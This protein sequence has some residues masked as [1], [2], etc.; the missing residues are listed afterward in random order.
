M[1]EVFQVSRAERNKKLDDVIKTSIKVGKTYRD[2][3][4]F[5][6]QYWKSTQEWKDNFDRVK[7]IVAREEKSSF[8]VI[9]KKYTFTE[10]KKKEVLE[11]YKFESKFISDLFGDI[12]SGCGC[13]DSREY[14]FQCSDNECRLTWQKEC[15]EKDYTLKEL[16]PDGC[17]CCA[18]EEYYPHM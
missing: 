5:R 8:A 6:V 17:P 4:S 3:D 18:F 16:L 7:K 15:L 12:P 14:D 11:D 9:T 13:E 10:E 2:T 1:G